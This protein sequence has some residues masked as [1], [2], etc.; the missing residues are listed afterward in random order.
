MWHSFVGC[1]CV[2]VCV[3]FI[4]EVV[5]CGRKYTGLESDNPSFDS[6][7]FYF[8]PLDELLY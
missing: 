1:V 5:Q 7:H 2:C 4:Q 6:Y 8:P 3:C